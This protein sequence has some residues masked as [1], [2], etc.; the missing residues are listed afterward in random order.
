LLRRND[1]FARTSSIIQ[2]LS[3]HSDEYDS[4]SYN[5]LFTTML[6]AY[7]SDLFSLLQKICLAYYKTLTYSYTCSEYNS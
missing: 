5:M 2:N 4:C 1:S 7:L 6:D 3:Y